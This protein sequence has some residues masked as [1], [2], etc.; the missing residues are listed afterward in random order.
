[1]KPARTRAG[2]SGRDPRLRA[3]AAHG[4]AES[5]GGIYI[6]TFMREIDTRGGIDNFKG[7]AI[8]DG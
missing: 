2:V 4:S 5:Y 6:P 8:G 7:A 1:M 3:G